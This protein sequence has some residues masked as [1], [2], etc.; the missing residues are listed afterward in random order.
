MT[1]VDWRRA[2]IEALSE[3]VLQENVDTHWETEAT[4]I[5]ESAEDDSYIYR[6]E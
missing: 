3:N 4:L 1:P 6:Y 5:A 2:L